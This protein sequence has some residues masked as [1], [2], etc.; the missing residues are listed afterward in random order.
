MLALSVL[1]IGYNLRDA[2]VFGKNV[3]VTGASRGKGLMIASGFVSSGANVF[4]TSRD[5]NGL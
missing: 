5:R 2:V 4:I 3:I 1:S